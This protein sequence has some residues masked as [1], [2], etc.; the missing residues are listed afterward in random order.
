MQSGKSVPWVRL[1]KPCPH[2]T[3]KGTGQFL[4]RGGINASAMP[5]N[6]LYLQCK[7]PETGTP[8]VLPLLKGGRFPCRVWEWSKKINS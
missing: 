2:R 1:G 6:A 5:K 3:M 8:D 4:G 7:V